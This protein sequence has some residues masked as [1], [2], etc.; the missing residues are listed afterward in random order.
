MARVH[1]GG[2]EASY[3]PSHGGSGDLGAAMATD[4]LA[5]DSELLLVARKKTKGENPL[6]FLV[7][8]GFF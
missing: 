7:I 4:G 5:R 3:R 2:G 8:D 1:P 6:G